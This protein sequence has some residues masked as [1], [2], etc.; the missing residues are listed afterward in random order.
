[1]SSLL[2]D[3][4]KSKK[5]KR[6]H[7]FQNEGKYPQT[8]ETLVFKKTSVNRMGGKAEN[9]RKTREKTKVPENH[10]FRLDFSAKKDCE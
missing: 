5:T 8:Q 7:G 6:L 10:H 3:V 1:M 4:N 9:Q 2:Y